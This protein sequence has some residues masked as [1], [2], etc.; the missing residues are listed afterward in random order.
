[1]IDEQA[2]SIAGVEYLCVVFAKGINPL[3]NGVEL[4]YERLII[5]F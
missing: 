3:S 4:G 5:A 1:M 2:L